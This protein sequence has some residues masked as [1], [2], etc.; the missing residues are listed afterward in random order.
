MITS[1]QGCS[2]SEIPKLIIGMTV[3]VYNPL[4]NN[5][6]IFDTHRNNVLENLK[7]FFTVV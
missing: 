4:K 2:T 3:R 5:I 6:E 1:D 7:I